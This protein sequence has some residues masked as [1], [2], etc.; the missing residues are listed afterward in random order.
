[1]SEEI[2]RQNEQDFKKYWYKIYVES[3]FYK[4]FLEKIRV[5]V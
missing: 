2:N 4:I 3:Y 5:R 1:M